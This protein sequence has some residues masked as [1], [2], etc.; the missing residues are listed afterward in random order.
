MLGI[1]YLDGSPVQDNDLLSMAQ[2]TPHRGPDGT[3]F[4][5]HDH[6]GLGHLRLH[7]TTEALEE[8]LPFHEADT[9]LL[10]TADVRLD[11]RTELI[12]KLDDPLPTDLSDSQLI[13]RAYQKWRADCVQHLLGDFAFAIWDINSQSLFC[14][15]DHLGQKPF[16]YCHIAGKRFAFASAAISVVAPMDIPRNVYLPRVADYLAA[17]LEG[18]N[19]TCSFFKDVYRLAPGHTLT[20]KGTSL[21]ISRY[22]Q[23]APITPLYLADNKEY[24]DALEEVLVAAV[25]ARVR[26]HKPVAAM[27][28]GGVDSSTL[29]GLAADIESKRG[30]S[31]LRTFSG[32]STDADCVETSYINEMLNHGRFDPICLRPSDV[33]RYRSALNDASGVEDPFDF[34]WILPRLIYRSARQHGHVAVI[35]GIDGDGVASMTSSYPAFLMRQGRFFSSLY[36]TRAIHARWRPGLLQR[37]KQQLS[38]FKTVFA[39]DWARRRQRNRQVDERYIEAIEDYFFS[40]EFAETV[41]LRERLMEEYAQTMKVSAQTLEEVQVLRLLAPYATAATERY[42]R[43]AASAGVE[44]RHPFGDK[45]VVEFFFNLPWQQK[46]FRGWNKV[47][48]RRVLARVAPEQVAWRLEHDQ[49]YWKFRYAWAQDSLGHHRKVMAQHR[50]RLGNWL[51]DQRLDA[52]LSKASDPAESYEMGDLASLLDWLAVHGD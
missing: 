3:S 41:A 46:N 36:E 34:T 4:F 26:S 17:D 47:C 29:A 9:N 19:N 23:P 44:T 35:D 45:R 52:F 15:R 11:N 6:I 22:W 7:T 18:V 42:G 10:M 51:D 2:E 28:S 48:L 5:K 49:I 16:Y 30:R 31:P 14:A 40:R 21:S 13:L 43:M 24:A 39:S 8:V 12:D 20:L 33:T 25:C 1:I 50:Q 32:I 38:V 37:V 27:V